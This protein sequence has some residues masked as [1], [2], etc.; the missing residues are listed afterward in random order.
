M[1]RSGT[2]LAAALALVAPAATAAPMMVQATLTIDIQGL[3]PVTATG[4]GTVSVT[5]GGAVLVPAGLVNLPST[6]IPIGASGISSIQ[7]SSLAN[8]SGTFSVGAATAAETC[9]TPAFGEACVAGGGLGGVM[10]L[11]GTIAVNVVPHLVVIPLN[12]NQ[13]LIGQGGSVTTPFIA[14]G[15]PWTTGT[16]RMG[17]TANGAA[18]STTGTN[19]GGLNLTL[20]TA[21]YVNACANI[22]PVLA[23]LELA[24]LVPEPGVLLLLGTGLAGLA[25]ARRWRR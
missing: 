9:A 5:G 7:V 17:F 24:P 18:V 6:T 3:V 10:G 8:Q 20:V 12:L 23:T 25:A 14:D 22:L 4:T 16:A 19:A 11:T 1:T 21:T 2:L 13:L 15:A